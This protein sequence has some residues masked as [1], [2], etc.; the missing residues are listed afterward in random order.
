MKCAWMRS[1]AG[2]RMLDL[3]GK[4]FGRWTIVSFS[5]INEKGA[6]YWQAKCDCGKEG[7]IRGS[8]LVERGSGSC[9]CLAVEKSSTRGGATK[10]RVFSC[11]KGMIRRC[12]DPREKKYH[13]YGGRGITVCERWMAF[14]NFLADMG[15]V[16][17]GMTLDRINPDGNYEPMNCRWATPTTQANNT[18]RNRKLTLNGVTHTIMEWS[19]IV[20]VNHE[21]IRRRINRGVSVKEAL[22]PLDAEMELQYEGLL[23]S[24]EGA[25]RE[26]QYK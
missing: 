26:G 4:R 17:D 14:E 8:S 11:W 2:K 9:G 23:I 15:E 22:R 24:L 16:P 1:P 7:V 13:L 5:H 10:L 25:E 12:T 20:G 18:R 6:S 3:T 21:T 19:R